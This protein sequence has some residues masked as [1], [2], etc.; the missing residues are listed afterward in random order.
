MTI[1]SGRRSSA[2]IP[3]SISHLLSPSFSYSAHNYKFRRF[4]CTNS[5]NSRHNSVEPPHPSTGRSQRGNRAHTGFHTLAP[6]MQLVFDARKLLE[7]SSD[8]PCNTVFVA[9]IGAQ[10]PLAG[11]APRRIALPGLGVAVHVAPLIAF[12]KQVIPLE[13]MFGARPVPQTPPTICVLGT[14]AAAGAGTAGCGTRG[15]SVADRAWG[16]HRCAE[17]TP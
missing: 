7:Q 3:S 1:S 10:H 12:G 4:Q 13:I 15:H 11:G 14:C 17:S 8:Y 9:M 2:R 5:A 6:V 16:R